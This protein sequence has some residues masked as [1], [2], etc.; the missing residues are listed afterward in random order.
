MRKRER[1]DDD[2][3]DDDDERKRYSD[4]LYYRFTP[5]G[6][7]GSSLIRFPAISLLFNA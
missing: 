6:R 5:P 1:D 7:L 2:D 4:R 3:E